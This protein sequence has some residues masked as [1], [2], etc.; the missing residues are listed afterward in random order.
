M[1]SIPPGLRSR[2]LL[3][4]LEAL[5]T[6][7]RLDRYLEL[8][9]PL[10]TVREMRAEIVEAHRCAAESVALRLRPT[11]QWRGFAAGQFVRV[12]V[13]V[14]GVR[15]VRCY[16]PVD[17]E[18]GP[19]ATFGLIVKAHPAGVVS[20]HLYHRATPGMVVD[21][22]PADGVFRLP[23]P[24]PANVLF[25]SGGSGITP[26]LSM[27]R[28]LL[29][30]AHPGRIAFLHYATGPDAVPHRVELAALHSEPN[31]AVAFGY[32]SA[33]GGDLT[34]HFD[35][36]HL[37]QIAPWYRDAHVFVCG[38][39]RLRIAV[40]KVFDELGLGDRVRAE[41]FDATVPAPT[42]PGEGTVTFAASGVRAAN[43]GATLLEQAEAAGL[44]PEHGCR[45]GIC[46]SC[47]A[48]KRCGRTRNLRTGAVDD[49]PDQRI[50]LCITAPLGDVSLDI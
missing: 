46:Y 18:H 6:P 36:D 38:P 43:T 12:G 35:L 13:V 24:R 37:A 4:F 33:R 29:D 21:L 17:S 45:M 39:A 50:Q 27:L 32:P 22:A 10:L 28:T 34:G 40:R 47:V 49:A 44:T 5:T 26:V 16:S 19:D 41:E 3:T 31:V 14:D 2:R 42:E 8:V 15:H 7:H 1:A 48:L 11:R 30:E 20:R 23:R 9:D 25:I